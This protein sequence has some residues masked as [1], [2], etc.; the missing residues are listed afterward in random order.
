MNGPV[1]VGL[2]D[3]GASDDLASFIADQ[4]TF[5]LDPF[6]NSASASRD[7]GDSLGHGSALARVIVAASPQSKLLIAR[8]FQDRLVT[9]PLVVAAALD[10]LREV[11]AR[12][13]NLSFGLRQDRDVLRASTARALEAGMLLFAAAPARGPPIFPGAY[14]G[15]IRVSGDAR[16]SPEEISVLGGAQA[17]FG[18]HP[19]PSQG[20]SGAGTAGGASFAVAH[21]TGIV[22]AHLAERPNADRAQ[23]WRFVAAKAVYHGREHR[24]STDD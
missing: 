4:R 3:S 20:F 14:P 17:D 5:T 21:L 6:G 19:G 22:A 16:C 12:L 18:A 10:W 2:P 7:M 23:V 24:I 9:Q 15:V 11:G 13:V 1:L 8:I